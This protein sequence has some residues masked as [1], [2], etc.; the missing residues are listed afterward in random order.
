MREMHPSIQVIDTQLAGRPGLTAAY[1][2][3]GER[4]ALVET[5]A[6][7]STETVIEALRAAGLGPGDLAWIVLTHIH[8][9]HCGAT[10]G[11]AAAFPDATVVVHPRGPRH[12]AD[13]ARL[14]AATAAVH[15]ERFPIYGGLDPTPAER[16]VAA[17]DGHLVDLGGGRRLRMIETP[18]HAKHHM[19]ILDE[20]TGTLFA[21]DLVGVSMSQGEQY[22]ATPPADIDFEGWL[23]SLD[24][25]ADV[26]PTVVCPAH[27]GPVE[28]AE[29]GIATAREQIE[30]LARVSSATWAA[31][32]GV[33]A[34]AR[35]IERELPLEGAVHDARALDNWRF[36]GWYE[37]NPDGVALWAQARAEA[38]AAG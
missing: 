4:P 7:T 1:L 19:A 30:T 20:E 10:G 8:L 37:A 11:V 12:L 2:I 13:P 17:E 24:R 27:F 32:G 25:V 14:V 3:A 9:D 35:A 21:G 34:L 38:A 16:I 6:H 29:R 23:T 18:G 31:G 26:R 15:G 28:D 33:P 36:V 22:P 5:G